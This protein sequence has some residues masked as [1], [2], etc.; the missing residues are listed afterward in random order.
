MGGDMRRPKSLLALVAGAMLMAFLPVD[1]AAAVDDA[2]VPQGLSTD[3]AD[4]ERVKEY[5]IKE[6][7]DRFVEAI[8]YRDKG[9]CGIF[10][11]IVG[12]LATA[13]TD[14]YVRESSR[15]RGVRLSRDQELAI[16]I[17]AR[18]RA[19]ILRSWDCPPKGEAVT[20][21][22]STWADKW[23]AV[24]IGGGPA[25]VDV[26]QDT[27]GTTVFSPG[28][29]GPTAKSEERLTGQSANILLGGPLGRNL[30]GFVGF[31][32]IWAEGSSG[33]ETDGDAANTYI[34]RNEEND[35]T[36]VGFPGG[37]GASTSKEVRILDAT[38]GVSGTIARFGGSG[39]TPLV[40]GDGLTELAG[41]IV[42]GSAG[43][44]LPPPGGVNVVGSAG[45]RVRDYRSSYDSFTE[46]LLF[47]DDPI[48]A[49]Q[50]FDID[51]TFVGG[52]IG[53]G[54]IYRLPIPDNA[55][56]VG[57]FGTAAFGQNNADATALGK[58]HADPLCPASPECDFS[59]KLNFDESNFSAIYGGKAV[60]GVSTGK[61][62]FEAFVTVEQ[63]T[64][65][66]AFS[67]VFT[68]DQQ[69]IHLIKDDLTAIAAGLNVTFELL[70][71][72]SYFPSD[73]RLKRDIVK[74]GR[75]A[76]GLPLYRYRYLWSDT[77][78]VGVMAQEVALLMPEAVARG[79]D[80]YLRVDY[81]RLGTRLMTLAAW[82]AMQGLSPHACYASY[83]RKP[84]F[85]G[86]RH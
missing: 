58:Y 64:D 75:L 59:Q 18:E 26:P 62:R 85:R 31:N 16:K 78:F 48:T 70:P 19:E 17:Y 68:P 7:D 14:E 29:E 43:N 67:Q 77:E 46:A 12:V 80:G 25:V 84:V 38:A 50:N 72:Q 61:V 83:R 34:A 53:G 40:R 37:Q 8:H 35:S 1:D 63:W 69:P 73:A 54:L 45:V 33:G 41:D 51:A 21:A 23:G 44:I 76:N 71:D 20:T 55:I 49:Q 81:G 24:G 52:Q 60:F 27:A 30:R 5:A 42:V 9:E 86:N 66:P 11:Y 15:N 57:I 79:D 65:A 47:I 3:P 4:R 22:T 2:A 13:F 82:S 39:V 32:G 74:V 56:H 10:D 36:G 28:K 6:I